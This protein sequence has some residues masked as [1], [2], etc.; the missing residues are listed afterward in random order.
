M[1]KKKRRK[2]KNNKKKLLLLLLVFIMLVSVI[3][4]KNTISN[5]IGSIRYGYEINTIEAFKEEDIY[6]II[7]E[8][9]YSKTLEEA[10]NSN[11]FNEKYL[12]EYLDIVYIEEKDFITNIN[13]LLDIGYN[14]IEINHIY[15]ALDNENIEIVLDNK[16][17]EYLDE[18]LKLPYFKKEYLERYLKYKISSK[19]T[20]AEDIVTYVNIGL[21]YD[22]Y[23]NVKDVKEYNDELIVNKYNKLASSY[24]PKLV[25]L[26]DKYGISTRKQQMTESAANAFA[27]L[28]EAA[29]LEGLTIKSGSAYR[30]Y[31]YQLNLYNRYVA[32]DG[33]EEA[34]TY[35]ARA[36]HSEHQTGLATDIMDDNYNYLSEGDPEYEWLINNS[37]KYGFILRYPK[38]KEHITGYMFEAWH[39]RYLGEELATEVYNSKLTYEEYLAR[40]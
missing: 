13:K 38:E 16:H 33:K 14:S 19:L 11:Q 35:A 28:C 39:F 23:D 9:D 1:S 24:V 4:F 20:N 17:D 5:L 22:Y 15:N 3:L 8:K 36:G 2:K 7:K 25:T 12:N 31:D 30:S 6:K 37:Y 27:K 18:Y 26:D 21:D 34:D 32:Q 40:K 29:A 10:I